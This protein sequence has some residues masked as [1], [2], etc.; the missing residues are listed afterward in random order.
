MQLHLPLSPIDRL[1]QPPLYY[2]QVQDGLILLVSTFWTV[3]YVLYVRQA[4]RDKSYGMPLL[5]LYDHPS[6]PVA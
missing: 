4:F 1:N 3:A 6:I 2:L 5:C